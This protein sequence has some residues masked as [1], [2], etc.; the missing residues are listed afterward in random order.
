MDAWFGQKLSWHKGQSHKGQ[1]NTGCSKPKESQALSPSMLSP[2][3]YSALAPSVPSQ[4]LS[5]LALVKWLSSSEVCLADAVS[6]CGIGASGACHR[7]G[8]GIANCLCTSSL[9]ICR[10][11]SKLCQHRCAALCTAPLH[12]QHMSMASACLDCPGR[13]APILSSWLV[14]VFSC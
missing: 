8:R 13:L 6:N 14:Y 11:L 3:L 10:S 2:C 4:H 9:R 5:H 7:P 1:S 12:Q